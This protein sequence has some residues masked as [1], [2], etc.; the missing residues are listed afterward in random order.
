MKNLNRD[1]WENRYANSETGWDIG[2]VSTP[3]KTYIDQLENKN[4]DILIPGAGNAYEAEYLFQNGFQSLVV[5]DIASKPLQN[6]LLRVHEFPKDK[7]IQTDFFDYQ[8]QFDLIVEQT[9]FCALHPSLRKNYV[10]KMAELLK[11][12]GKLT[13][14]FFD[15]NLTD[16]GPPFGGSVE[17][18]QSLFEPL[19]NI[20]KLERCHNSILPRQGNELF[21]IFEKK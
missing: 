8:G 21:F 11:P 9:F 13:G 20:K 3:V 7:L 6:L 10:V 1:F 17:E 12:K 15:F 4:I 16:E 18:Y 19:F 14:L 5:I 2:A